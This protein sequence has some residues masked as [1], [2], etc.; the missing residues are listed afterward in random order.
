MYRR[1][2]SDFKQKQRKARRGS[3]NPLHTFQTRPREG[4]DLP[5]LHSKEKAE[6]LGQAELS[7]LTINF[8]LK[9][10]IRWLL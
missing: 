4:K 1:Q 3:L 7:F 9:G 8:P 5:K 10:E 2:E 6:A